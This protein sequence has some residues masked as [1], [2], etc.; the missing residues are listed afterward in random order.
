MDNNIDS[1][2]R[3]SPKDFFLNLGVMV[4]LYASTIS[5]LNL[6]FEIIN[7]VWPD[8]LQ[9]YYYSVGVYSASIRWSIAV[10]VVI[11]PIYLLISWYFGRDFSAN[12]EK[13]NLPIRKWLTYL[14]LFL[15][16]IAIIIDL[17]TLINTFLGGEIT[18]RFVLKVVAVLAVAGVIFGYYIY[19]LRKG[20]ENG[21]RGI[22]AWIAGGVVLAT[23]IGGFVVI[24]S[25]TTARLM[26]FDEQRVQDLQNIQ[27]QI[28]NYWQQKGTLPVAL[29][30]LN[31]SISGYVS[32]VD[33]DKKTQYIY[34]RTG[35][36]TFKLCADFSRASEERNG[37]ISKPYGYEL[38]NWKHGA[39]QTCF[40]RTIDP[41]LYPVKPNMIR[42]I[43]AR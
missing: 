26:R 32:P 18:T 20:G 12:P 25:P 10:L 34:E 43:P 4:A 29:S 3:M 19:D 35:L 9:D 28:T 6:L 40:D 11:F 21:S 41:E 1:R 24:G 30:E 36:R 42:E 5:L 13:R 15:A 38:E 17:I 8:A 39:G 37:G 7:R 14:T 33:P 22:F 23:I 16:G 27:W 2:P 31:D